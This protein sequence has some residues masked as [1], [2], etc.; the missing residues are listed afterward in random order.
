MS[1]ANDKKLGMDRSITRRDFLNGVAVTTGASLLPPHLHAALQHDLDPEKSP[2]YYPP[3]L[4]GLRGSHVGSFEVAHNVRDGDFWQKAGKPIETREKFDLIVVG[5]GIS[6]LSSAYFFRKSNPNARILILDN[7][8]DFGGHAK[9]NEFTTGDRKLLGFGGSFSIESPAPNSAV[10]KGVIQDLGID[11][12]SFSK[13][14]DRELYSS[15]GL[16]PSVFFDKETFG[17]DALTANP[18]PVGGTSNEGDDTPERQKVW[19]RF[20]DKA[21]LSEN[22]KA[23]LVRLR[24]GEDYYPGLTSDEKKARLAR[25]SFHSSLVTPCI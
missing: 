16:V 2:D 10:A 1:D 4:V 21:P 17:A 23:D 11:V 6:G 9:R 7:H 22:A 8:D 3:A 20:F 13:H 25:L 19:D 5:G 18:L 14:I 12:H 15:R 24:K